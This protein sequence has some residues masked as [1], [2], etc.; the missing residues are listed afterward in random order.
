MAG[1]RS[2]PA[3]LILKCGDLHG[4]RNRIASVVAQRVC[5]F[6]WILATRSTR[7]WH[8]F[9]IDCLEFVMI[10]VRYKGRSGK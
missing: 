7:S 4:G 2:R 9:N 1:S 8:P 6:F 3:A 10:D 5:R